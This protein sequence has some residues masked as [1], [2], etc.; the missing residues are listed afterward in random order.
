MCWGKGPTWT[1]DNISII[2]NI[3]EKTVIGKCDD[4]LIDASASNGNYGQGWNLIQWR[5]DP[6]IIGIES[7]SEVIST[8]IRLEIQGKFLIEEVEYEFTLTLRNYKRNT[9]AESRR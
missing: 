5:S 8:D 7:K 2:F 6:P 3:D 4:V 1:D 9:T